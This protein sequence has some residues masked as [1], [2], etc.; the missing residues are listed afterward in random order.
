[1]VLIHVLG[2]LSYLHHTLATV[3]MCIL[4]F[5]KN[6]PQRMSSHQTKLKHGVSSSVSHE[7]PRSDNTVNHHISV[8]NINYSGILL[9]GTPFNQHSVLSNLLTLRNT[10]NSI[11]DLLGIVSSI[12]GFPILA[13]LT[14]NFLMLVGVSYGFV[15]FLHSNQ[16]REYNDVFGFSSVASLFSRCSCH[17]SDCSLL[18][19]LVRI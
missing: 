4:S 1:M 18:R 17:F 12:Y 13:E 14:Q 19:L 10:Y 3:N 9:C 11:Y 16:T 5:F 7:V 6:R 15:L 2:F 8:I